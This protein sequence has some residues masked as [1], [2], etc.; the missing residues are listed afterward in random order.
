MSDI[1]RIE[2]TTFQ[3]E[4]GKLY[5]MNQQIEVNGLPAVI[6]Q[7]EYNCSTNSFIVT[8]HYGCIVDGTVKGLKCSELATLPENASNGGHDYQSYDSYKAGGSYKVCIWCDEVQR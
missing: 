6:T 3:G 8:A 2:S 7:L 5:E 4:E 1:A